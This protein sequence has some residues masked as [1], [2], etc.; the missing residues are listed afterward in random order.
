[1]LDQSGY[2]N[3]LQVSASKRS[4]RCRRQG[5]R[6]TTSGVRFGHD[7]NCP[8]GHPKVLRER[9]LRRVGNLAWPNQ[10]QVV[11]RRH[12]LS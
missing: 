10:E 12:Y 8:P 6:E 4:E 11:Q 3:N 2:R 7:Q 5:V 1:M 9:R